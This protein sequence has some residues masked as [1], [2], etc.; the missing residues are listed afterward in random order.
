MKRHFAIH[1]KGNNHKWSFDFIADDKHW[2]TWLD[3]GL[4][5]YAVENVDS[6]TAEVFINESNIELN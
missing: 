1:V 6:E 3:D 5:V 2:Q 4:E